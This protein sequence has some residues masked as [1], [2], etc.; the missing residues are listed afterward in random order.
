MRTLVGFVSRGL[1]VEAIRRGN[2]LAVE[3]EVL[4]IGV[5]VFPGKFPIYRGLRS[6]IGYVMPKINVVGADCFPLVS[7]SEGGYV[8]LVGQKLERLLRFKM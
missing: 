1:A 3:V 7:S 5:L 4:Q 2:F 8:F 6:L